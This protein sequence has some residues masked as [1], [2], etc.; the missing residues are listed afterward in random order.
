M[1]DE[2]EVQPPDTEDLG[3]VA[4][5]IAGRADPLVRAAKYRIRARDMPVIRRGHEEMS[6]VMFQ[7]QEIHTALSILAVSKPD[8][9]LTQLVLDLCSLVRDEF[10]KRMIEPETPARSGRTLIRSKV[11][12]TRRQ[13]A[14]LRLLDEGKS[15]ADVAA[16]LGIRPGTVASHIAGMKDQLQI[17]GQ[18]VD[19]VTEAH[20]RGILSSSN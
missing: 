4:R 13:M 18:R 3:A 14:V 7:L 19:L 1:S 20:R 5:Y 8:D 10:M 9:A 15:A 2:A 6:Y 16:E 11:R 17:T 12:L